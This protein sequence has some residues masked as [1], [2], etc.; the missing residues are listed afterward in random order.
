MH[1]YVKTC[2]QAA[3]LGGRILL[4]YRDRM[5]AREKGPAD[6]VTEADLASQ[7]AIRTFLL[8]Q[9]PDH[10][11]VC[12]EDWH[13]EDGASP[14]AATA[15]RDPQQPVWLVDPLDGTTNYVHGLPNYC[16]SVGLRI[17]DELAAGAVFDP[18]LG[19]SFTAG[20]GVAAQLNDESIRAS[21]VEAIGEALV[22]LSFPVRPAIDS[23]A[24]RDLLAVLPLSQAFRRM[25][26]SALNLCYVAAGRLDAY[27][28]RDTKIWDIAAGALIAQQAGALVTSIDGGPIDF[29]R[30]TILTAGSRSLH[31]RLLKLLTSV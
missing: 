8:E 25:G 11:F 10:G 14:S 18:I 17:G 6:L 27:W 19:E 26:S 24:V 22:A 5:N 4:D 16:V 2:E 28:A 7:R 3:R 30:A 20:K 31:Q 1:Q 15:R 9:Y 23:P 12:E 29:D 13:V 21:G